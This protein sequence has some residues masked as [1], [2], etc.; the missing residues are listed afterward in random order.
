MIVAPDG[1]LLAHAGE[2]ESL[3]CAGLDL[4]LVRKTREH[5]RALEDRVPD[6]YSHE[7]KNQAM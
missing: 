1:R 7:E 3:L 4:A 6:A 2:E 5:I